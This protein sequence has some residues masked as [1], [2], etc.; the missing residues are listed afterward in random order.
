MHKYINNKLSDECRHQPWAI[1][2]KLDKAFFT[3]DFYSDVTK[4]T[5]YFE[6]W[7][8]EMNNNTRSFNPFN[9]HRKQPLF[10]LIN[11]RKSTGAYS[12]IPFYT[13]DYAFFDNRLNS[14]FKKWNKAASREQKFMET[15]YRA[16]EKMV[17]DIYKL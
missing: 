3:G 1:D 2:S 16:T 10:D 15:F 6:E 11:D 8:D 9:I 17:K 5:S 14:R 12:I 13:K 7:L 4:F